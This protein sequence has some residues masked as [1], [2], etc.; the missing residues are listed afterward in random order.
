MTTKSERHR[1]H[2]H[3]YTVQISINTDATSR[4]LN[5]SLCLVSQMA[6]TYDKTVAAIR[7]QTYTQSSCAHVNETKVQHEQIWRDFL[8]DNNTNPLTVTDI[9]RQTQSQQGM[10]GSGGWTK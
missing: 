3:A 10:H 2:T 4:Q 7:R 1:S 5:S 8:P 6:S 9:V